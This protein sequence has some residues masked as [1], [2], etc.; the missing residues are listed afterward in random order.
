ML[1]QIN[2]DFSRSVAAVCLHNFPISSLYCHAAEKVLQF[3][4]LL[5]IYSTTYAPAQG[6]IKR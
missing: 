3:N 5:V 4:D 1:E 2:A 6:S